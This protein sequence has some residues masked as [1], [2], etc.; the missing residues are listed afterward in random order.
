M[1]QEDILIMFQNKIDEIGIYLI[2][3][4]KFIY[5]LNLKIQIILV[6]KSRKFTPNSIKIFLKLILL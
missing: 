5:V 3:N 6:G 2:Y 4:I 1:S